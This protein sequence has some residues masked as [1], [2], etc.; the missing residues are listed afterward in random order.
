MYTLTLYHY[1][2]FKKKTKKNN[3]KRVCDANCIY[4]ET[5]P[6]RAQSDIYGFFVL[7]VCA[8]ADGSRTT[9]RPNKN[10]K[11]ELN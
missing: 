8:F 3:D 7:F 1:V 4:C 2:H 10:G 9:D 6:P 11:K 5:Y